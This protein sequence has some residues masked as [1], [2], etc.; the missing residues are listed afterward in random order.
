MAVETGDEE[1]LRAE[2]LWD[3]VVN[4]KMYVT[5]GI[6]YPGSM[7]IAENMICPI[8]MLTLKPVPL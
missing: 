4:K 7:R 8:E 3:N 6:G 2:R 5:G 1:L